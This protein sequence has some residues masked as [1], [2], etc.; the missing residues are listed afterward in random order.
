AIH[1]PNRARTALIVPTR[2]GSLRQLLGA[3][4]SADPL[5]LAQSGSERLGRHEH[6]S[7]PPDYLAAA[8]RHD[9]REA[10]VEEPQTRHAR[11]DALG[12][13]DHPP[14]SRVIGALMPRADRQPSSSTW[15]PARSARRCR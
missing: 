1:G 2:W 9:P 4:R 8:Q 14:V 12:A 10:P 5:L 6:L 11:K 13:D 15:P 3:T 7:V